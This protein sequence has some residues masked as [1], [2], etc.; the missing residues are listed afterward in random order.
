MTNIALIPY[1]PKHPSTIEKLKKNQNLTRIITT[2][3]ID[4]LIFIILFVWKTKKY[5]IQH[6]AL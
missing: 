4:Y 5:T 2:I 6:V 3:Y 1:P